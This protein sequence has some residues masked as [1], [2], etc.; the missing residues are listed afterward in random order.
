MRKDNGEFHLVLNL[1][2][3]KKYIPYKHFKMENSEQ[4]IR[5]QNKGEK[6]LASADLRHAYYSVKVADDP[7]R[8]L[9]FTWQ[10]VMYQFTCLPN[11][12]SEGPRFSPN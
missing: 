8:F 1:E 7:H 5:T 9:C 6:F 4:A 12:I 2:S 3:F 10:G 11:G